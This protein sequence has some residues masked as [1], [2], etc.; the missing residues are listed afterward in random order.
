MG[1]VQLQ[2]SS[3]SGTSTMSSLLVGLVAFLG[4]AG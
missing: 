4:G 3:N 2:V 1:G